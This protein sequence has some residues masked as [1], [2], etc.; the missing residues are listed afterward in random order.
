MPETEFRVDARNSAGTLHTTTFIEGAFL[1]MRCL[2]C[3]AV[4]PE[5]V[6]TCPLHPDAKKESHFI[7]DFAT[8]V[9]SPVHVVENSD[10]YPL[11]KR[12]RTN[13]SS[14]TKIDLVEPTAPLLVIIAQLHGSPQDSEDDQHVIYS[15]V[16]LELS[17][18][19]ALDEGRN[20]SALPTEYKW[21]RLSHLEVTNTEET[22][23][24]I[25]QIVSKP[26][27]ILYYLTSTPIVWI[28]DDVAITDTLNG[29]WKTLATNPFSTLIGK[30]ADLNRVL[31]DPYDFLQGPVAHDTAESFAFLNS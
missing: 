20:P 15:G 12:A 22:L 29:F 19:I 27:P 11:A 25:Y 17:E 8:Q 24:W 6:Y 30:T 23:L 26:E 10:P 3:C 13:K 9:I 1:M 16:M 21:E 18:Y 4:L 31:D 2:E 5:N 28:N 14:G 7:Q